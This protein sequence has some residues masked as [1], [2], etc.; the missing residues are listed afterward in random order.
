MMNLYIGLENPRYQDFHNPIQY[1]KLPY[2]PISLSEN[3]VKI[4]DLSMS[5][6]N[7]IIIKSNHQ[8][9]TEKIMTLKERV[10]K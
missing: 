1:L 6:V 3:G 9:P 10:R 4:K 2:Q 7:L 8:F 5:S